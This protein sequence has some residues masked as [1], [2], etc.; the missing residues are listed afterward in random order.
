[1]DNAE[2]IFIFLMSDFLMPDTALLI[3]TNSL[4]SIHYSH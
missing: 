4:F 3:F 1:M 2:M